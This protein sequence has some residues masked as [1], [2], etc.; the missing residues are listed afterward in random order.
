ML[1][2][3]EFNEKNDLSFGTNVNCIL[4]GCQTYTSDWILA[5]G[6]EL[7]RFGFELGTHALD[8]LLIID[9]VPLE[10]ET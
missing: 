5:L 2:F 6:R 4:E 7:G 8:V 9:D 1:I 10:L 3:L